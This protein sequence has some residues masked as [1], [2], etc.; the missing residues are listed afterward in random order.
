V[1]VV[2]ASVP[3]PIRALAGFRRVALQPGERRSVTFTLAPRQLSLI[4]AANQRVVEPGTFELSVGGK[5]PGFRGAADAATTEVVTAR[6]Q[7]T[8]ARVVV[9]R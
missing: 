3:V 8:G 4:D 1:T 7:V 6:L 5:Q 2:S 9:G